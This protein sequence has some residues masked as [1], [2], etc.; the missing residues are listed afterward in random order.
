MAEIPLRRLRGLLRPLRFFLNAEG[1]EDFAEVAKVHAH[2]TELDQ[3]SGF[4]IRV[5][6]FIL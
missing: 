2:A 6:V 1:A 3:I 5:L 4:E